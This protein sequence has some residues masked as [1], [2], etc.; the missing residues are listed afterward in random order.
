MLTAL[1]R[2][3]KEVMPKPAD[4]AWTRAMQVIPSQVV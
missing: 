4:V 3:S 2:V 1:E